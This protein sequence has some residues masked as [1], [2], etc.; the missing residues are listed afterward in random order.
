MAIEN[1]VREVGFSEHVG[2][3]PSDS[4]Y[5]VLDYRRYFEEIEDARARFSASLEIRMGVEID[6]RSAVIAQTRSYLEAHKFDF[7]IGAVHYLE[8]EILLRARIF[9]Q[10]PWRE[11]WSDYF[12]EV[13]AMVRTGLFDI[14]AHLDV[15]K[16]GHVPLFGPFDWTLF[17]D[18]IVLILKEIVIQ[19]CALEVNTAGL[20]KQAGEMFPSPGIL[21]L[22]RELGG[23]CVT[24]GSDCHSPQ[25]VGR[26]LAE[27]LGAVESA[28]F[29]HICT[30]RARQRK[31]VPVRISGGR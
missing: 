6:F 21:N 2:I 16:R 19:D 8:G 23:R 13:L 5:G 18:R 14:V 17:E 1:G 20:R 3:D 11:V 29:E 25:K 22:Y 28:G 15:P 4:A 12:D 7:V 30:F 10:R 26:D 31:L 24:T 9:E 27:A